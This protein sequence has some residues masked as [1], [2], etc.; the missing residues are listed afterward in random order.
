MRIAEM[1]KVLCGPSSEEYRRSLYY[2][3]SSLPWQKTETI[4]Q[5]LVKASV[6]NPVHSW[7]HERCVI[8]Y[9]ESLIEQGKEGEAQ[10]VIKKLRDAYHATGRQLRSVE[11][12]ALLSDRGGPEN[13]SLRNNYRRRHKYIDPMLP[14]LHPGISR[15]FLKDLRAKR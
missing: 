2:A 12:S 3:T 13:V 4:L 11:S 7:S 5:P 6:T 10:G 15:F 1:F 8:R 14:R 9:T